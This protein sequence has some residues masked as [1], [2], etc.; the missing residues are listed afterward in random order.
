MNFEMLSLA[1]CESMKWVKRRGKKKGEEEGMPG[2]D[3]VFAIAGLLAWFDL[4]RSGKATRMRE[5]GR[6]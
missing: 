1:W 2:F 6:D 3:V 5:K 4:F